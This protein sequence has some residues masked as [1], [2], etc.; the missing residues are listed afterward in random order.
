MKNKLKT[1]LK[2]N[3]AEATT[4][5]SLI[6]EFMNWQLNGDDI[7]LPTCVA[8]ILN[9]AKP[10]KSWDDLMPIV[11]KISSMFSNDMEDDLPHRVMCV[12]RHQIDATIES[13]YADVIEFIKWHN[14][15]RKSAEG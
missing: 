2:T 7:L 10:S 1:V 8:H 12:T 15:E 11:Q 5:N 13:V 6:A 14:T 3:E 4:D 9:I